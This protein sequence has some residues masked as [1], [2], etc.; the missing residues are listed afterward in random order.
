MELPGKVKLTGT[1]GRSHRLR[2]NS[3][4][5]ADGLETMLEAQMVGTHHAALE[6]LRQAMSPSQTF[7]GRNAVLTQ[8][9]RLM[10]L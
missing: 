9:Q 3:I 2:S 6:C 10:S 7:E 4:Q 8:A 5:P 1:T